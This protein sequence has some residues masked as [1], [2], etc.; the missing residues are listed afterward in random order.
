M[1]LDG[2]Y[3]ALVTPFATDGSLD[4]HSL[5]S[6]V[7]WQIEQGIDGLVPCG[8]TGESATLTPE[9]HVEVIRHVVDVAAGRVPVVAGTGSNNTREAI[10][11]TREART[12]GADGALLISP[13]YNKPTQDGIFHH[14]RTI[15][16]ETGLP[17]VIYNVPGRTASR[18]EPETVARLSRVDGI[19]GLKEAGGDLEKT[20]EAIAASE[21]DFA[22]VSGDDSLTLPMLSIGARGVISTIGNVAP[23]LTAEI[24]RAFGSGD[25]ARARAAALPAAAADDGALLREQSHSSED[26]RAPDR[27]DPQRDAA[28]AAHAHAEGESRP[29]GGGPLGPRAMTRACV[30]GAAGR[31]GAHVLRAVENDPELEVAAA[32]D[33]ADHPDLG[34]EVSPGVPLSADPAAAMAAADVAIDF[35]TPASTLAA[36][37]E[38]APRG[39]GVV[40][41]TTG[42]DEAQTAEL[43]AAA[44]SIAIVQSGNFSLG[45]AALARLVAEA[46]R[47]LPDY[48]IEVLEMHH[49]RK[50]DAPS[51][52][53][54]WLAEVAAEARGRVLAD[55][56]CFHREGHT[57]A[58]DPDEIGIQSLRGGDV[59]GEHTV[60]LVGPG[61][62]LQLAHLALSRDNFAA[63]AVRAA[64]W[65]AGR[66]PGLYGLHDVLD[67]P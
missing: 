57:G 33:R 22:V 54:L 6:L 37:R 23:R 18:I 7:E 66:A 61:E 10:G 36:L 40:L 59:V 38:A 26:R 1:T 20:A 16:E 52:T 53:A 3:T 49:N 9:E 28:A 30:I 42:F 55:V 56:A 24:C 48:E 27:Q 2:T 63:G 25:L 60:Y 44:K 31:M 51:G 14:Y 50:V 13:Y 45:V 11:F 21:D 41:A 15:A 47:A 17:L 39:V 8:S 32:L 34:K 43:R 19:V 46:A 64:R 65:L 67:R 5:A 4:L 62:R 29:A 58:R 12:A 35:S